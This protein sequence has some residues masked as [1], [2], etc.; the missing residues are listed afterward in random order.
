MRV[1]TNR[2]LGWRG[3]R[4]FPNGGG[5]PLAE[6]VPKTQW[7]G[8]WRVRLPDGSLSD[9]VNITRA[10]DAARTLA[11]VALNRPKKAA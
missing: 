7:K 9:I 4:L 5:A 10:R 8:M 3:N 6:I 2:E 1:W 11:L